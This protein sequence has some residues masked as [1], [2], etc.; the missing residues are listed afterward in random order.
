MPGGTAGAVGPKPVPHKIMT[1]PGLA[2]TVV[3]PANVPFFTAHVKSLWVATGCPPGQ[4]NNPGSYVDESTLKAGLLP[5]GVFT[6]TGT[7]PVPAD[8]GTA[9]LICVG[10]T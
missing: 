6:T 2:G 10:L 7:T 3:A 9:M 5:A 1:S 8:G 4:R